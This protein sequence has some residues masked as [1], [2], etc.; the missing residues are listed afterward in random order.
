VGIVFGVARNKDSK[1]SFLI[2][3]EF[4]GAEKLRTSQGANQ[5]SSLRSSN[6]DLL[7]R[8][9]AVLVFWLKIPKV[10]R[11]LSLNFRILRGGIVFGVA[12]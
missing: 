11:K 5:N 3:G 7:E 2:T 9:S 8:G 10:P 4:F 1:D 12:R 6:N